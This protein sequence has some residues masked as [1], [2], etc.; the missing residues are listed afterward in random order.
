MVDNGWRVELLVWV[1][2]EHFIGALEWWKGV[3]SPL[4]VFR[5]IER[6]WEGEQSH[7]EYCDENA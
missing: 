7:G 5:V 2:S 3:G 1:G 4:G 6:A